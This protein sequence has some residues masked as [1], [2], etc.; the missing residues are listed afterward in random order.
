M[1]R[2]IARPPST[3]VF[4]HPKGLVV[5]AGTEFWERVSFHGMQALLVLYMVE[6][7]LFPG[8]VEHVLGFGSF[9]AGIEW[10]TGPLSTQA[11]A[12]QIF[13][14]YIGL[15]YMTPLLGGVLGDRVLGRRRTVILGGSLMTAGTPTT[16]RSRFP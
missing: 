10:F 7:L 14:I 8:H 13:G 2:A 12:F 16:G 5:L 15:V 3:D 4:G 9:R 1:L 11:L 6:Q